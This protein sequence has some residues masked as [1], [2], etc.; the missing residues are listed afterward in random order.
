[1]ANKILITDDTAFM[2][3]TLKNILQKNG[4]EIAGEAED[5]LQAV[6]KYKTEQPDLVTMDITMPNMDGISAIKEIMS[7]DA[8]AKI[9]V[10]SAMGQKSLVIEALSSGAKDFIVKPFQPDRILDAVKKVLG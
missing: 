8:K 1:M 5:G 6:E 2:R 10:C 7:Y 9:I 4:Y 3:M